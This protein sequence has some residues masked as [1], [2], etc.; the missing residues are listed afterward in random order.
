[1]LNK[2]A[3][4][5]LEQN[6]EGAQKIAY[7]MNDGEGL[8]AQELMLDIKVDHFQGYEFLL[9]IMLLVTDDSAIERTRNRLF[10]RWFRKEL[11]A[12]GAAQT[13]ER[14]ANILSEENLYFETKRKRLI[15]L[16]KQN[17]L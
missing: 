3:L 7:Y 4:E 15:E 1:M 10:I 8:S 9:A 2:E 6:I 17:K 12:K 13:V 5:C 16:D 14:I 11:E